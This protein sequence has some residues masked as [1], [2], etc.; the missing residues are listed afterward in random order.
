MYMADYMIITERPPIPTPLYPPQ[1]SMQGYM[2]ITIYLLDCQVCG[3]M[4]KGGGVRG[5]VGNRRIYLPPPKF[6]LYY[7]QVLHKYNILAK[8]RII[9]YNTL[10]WHYLSPIYRNPQCLSL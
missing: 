5:T 1:E 8:I 6:I 3:V 4:C 9:C 10:I 2:W 7:T